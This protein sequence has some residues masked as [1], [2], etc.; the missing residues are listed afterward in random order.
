MKDRLA[1]IIGDGRAA[2]EALPKAEQQALVDEMGSIA[3]ARRAAWGRLPE[4]ERMR[5]VRAAGAVPVSTGDAAPEAPA[6]GAVRVVTMQGMCPTGETGFELQPIGYRGRQTM[7]R[8]DAVDVMAHQAAQKKTK[9]ALTPAQVEMGRHY[10]ALFERCE[11]SD[12][13]G[14][15]ME[16]TGGRSVGA[17]GGDVNEARLEER[18]RLVALQRRIGDGVAMP[19]RRVR[20]SKRGADAKPRRAISDRQLVDGVFV[21]GLTISGL[22]KKHNW[23]LGGAT[24]QAATAALA[25]ALDRLSGPAPRPRMAAAFYG[26]R[27]SWPAEEEV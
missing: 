21:E 16:M 14:S 11:A 10:A 4:A 3:R 22:L 7:R 12:M 17:R 24:V 13:R 18:R 8:A 26:T 19:I 5:L 15:S 25:A 23:G 2:L 27:A 1:E 6:R 20:P 9:V